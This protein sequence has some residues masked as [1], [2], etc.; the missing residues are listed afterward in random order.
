MPANN[1]IR[2]HLHLIEVDERHCYYCHELLTTDNISKLTN[3]KIKHIG[4]KNDGVIQDS[5]RLN[6]EIDDSDDDKDTLIYC[7]LCGTPRSL[8]PILDGR[9]YCCK[10]NKHFSYSMKNRHKN[11]SKNKNSRE[12]RAE[13]HRL[14][15]EKRRNRSVA[16]AAVEDWEQHTQEE[17]IDITKR[18]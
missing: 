15:E 13:K 1:E 11:P 16:N 9:A 3:G 5:S 12:R 4:C 14:K 6:I 2:R 8:P 7:I 10:C 17:E 18:E